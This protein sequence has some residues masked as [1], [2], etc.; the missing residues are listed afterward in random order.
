MDY[1]IDKIAMHLIDGKSKEPQFSKNEILLNTFD[2]I[3]REKI[4]EFFINHIKNACETE[5]RK[6]VCSAIF[7]NNSIIRDNFN[8]IIKDVSKFFDCS[9]TI[10]QHLCNLSHGP[11]ISPGLLI[12]GGLICLTRKGESVEYDHIIVRELG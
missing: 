1:I 3:D 11:N 6:N 8:M 4:S 10:A 2:P 7:E 5:E 12:R 9:K